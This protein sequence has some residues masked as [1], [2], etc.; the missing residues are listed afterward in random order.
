MMNKLKVTSDELS[1]QSQQKV[2]V[3]SSIEIIGMGV[4]PYI[5]EYD[6]TNIPK[7]H[8]EI[9]INTINAINAKIK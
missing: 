3:E 6:F 8:H 7:Q 5:I 4:L 2:K 1:V 9:F